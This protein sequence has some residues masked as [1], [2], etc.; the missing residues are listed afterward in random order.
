VNRGGLS[1]PLGNTSP[2]SSCKFQSST[3][4]MVLKGFLE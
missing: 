1:S 3:R 2:V 4:D